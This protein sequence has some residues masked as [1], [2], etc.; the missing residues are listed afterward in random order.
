MRKTQTLSEWSQI[1]NNSDACAMP[2]IP[3][4]EVPLN[5]H[6]K[7][8]NAYIKINEVVQPAPAPRF[9]RTPAGY[10]NAPVGSGANNKEILSE[11]GFSNKDIDKI[12]SEIN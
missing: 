5:K 3:L 11:I 8:R 6:N 1:F 2:I 10:P 9:G 7:A 4:S 12:S